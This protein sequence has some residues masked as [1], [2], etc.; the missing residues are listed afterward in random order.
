MGCVWVVEH[1][2][3]NPK[4]VHR[5]EP[6]GRNGELVPIKGGRASVELCAR[7][8]AIFK[9][10]SNPSRAATLFEAENRKLRRY[11]FSEHL[12]MGGDVEGEYQN[13]VREVIADFLE[14]FTAPQLER[15]RP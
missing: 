9:E 6:C 1:R 8:R 15:E 11:F 2:L 14:L 12:R 3:R 4:W 13:I 10:E 5:R 7:H